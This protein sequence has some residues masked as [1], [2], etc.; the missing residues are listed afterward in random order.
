MKVDLLVRGICRLVP[1]LPGLS[2]NIRVKS[3]VGRFLEHHRV[4]WFHH[5]G[6]PRVYIGSADLMERNLDRRVEVLTPVLEARLI[7]RL[8][9]LLQRYID[10]RARTR[11][12]QPDATYARLRQ[13]PGDPDVH[14]Q[15]MADEG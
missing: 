12:M 13:G 8:Q 6:K 11:E 10:D 15:F 3:V 14:A 1:G 5:G 7:R 2:E 9:A 4:Y